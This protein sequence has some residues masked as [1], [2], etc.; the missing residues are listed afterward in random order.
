MSLFERMERKLERTVNGVF[1]RAFRAEVQPLELA[2][3]LRRA[4]DDRATMLGRGR[5]LGDD[6]VEMLLDSPAGEQ[7]LGMLARTAVGTGE[8]VAAWLRDFAAGVQADEVI[9]T[10]A[11]PDPAVRER[12]LRIL[13]EHVVRG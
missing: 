7:V 9:V 12:T 5:T 3:A 2:S 10:T 13:G 4:M 6:E 1:A 11:A 8:T